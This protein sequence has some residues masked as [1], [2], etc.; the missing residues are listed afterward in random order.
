MKKPFTSNKKLYFPN[1]KALI[2]QL[3]ESDLFAANGH[4]VFKVL[5]Q[6]NGSLIVA[7]NEAGDGFEYFSLNKI[8]T[9]LFV[10]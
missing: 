5:C 3:K 2:G 4:Q 7:S 9:R 10:P 1:G 6:N 8:V